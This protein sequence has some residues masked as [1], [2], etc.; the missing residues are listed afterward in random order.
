MGVLIVV[1]TKN[2][3]AKEI[4]IQDICW[5]GDQIPILLHKWV[6]PVRPFQKNTLEYSCLTLLIL[7]SLTPYVS[8]L[9]NPYSL[10]RRWRN[11]PTFPS[12]RTTVPGPGRSALPK[13]SFWQ[14]KLLCLAASYT[15]SLNNCWIHLKVLDHSNS[16][17]VLKSI[18]QCFPKGIL[19]NSGSTGD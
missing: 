9:S 18:E 17:P 19:R 15:V 1:L 12:A 3:S 6:G 2:P 16:K 4:P 13:A 11:V 7:S 10:G 5:R 8:H 14:W